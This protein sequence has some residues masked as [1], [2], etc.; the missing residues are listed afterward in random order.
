MNL[1]STG[2]KLTLRIAGTVILYNPDKDVVENIKSY[3]ADIEILYVVDNSEVS[4]SKII[5]QILQ[6]DKVVYLNNGKNLGI[7]A[8]LNIAAGKAIES[9]YDFLLTMDQDS[10]ATSGMLDAMLDSVTGEDLTKIGIIAPFQVDDF[11]DK[12]AGSEKYEIIIS[13]MTSGNL[14]NLQIYKHIGKFREDFFIDQ[15]DIEYCFNLAK[16]GYLVV[17]ANKAIL[18]HSLGNITRVKFLNRQLRTSNHPALRRYYMTRNRF[19]VWHE[20]QSLE[21]AKETIAKDKICFRGEIRN[22]L[23]M[24]KDKVAKLFMIAKGYIDYKRKRFG[25]YTA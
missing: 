2:Q 1:D 12:R 19:C 16:R 10:F 24:E 23:L 9:G 22:I 18:L 8:A 4:D 7:A 20:Y 21:A 6:L 14:L 15:V 5:D 11:D 25:K 17:R 13:T 3:L